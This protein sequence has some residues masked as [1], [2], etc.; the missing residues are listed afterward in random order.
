MRPIP[1][2]RSAIARQGD[3]VSGVALIVVSG[4]ASL[5]V[6]LALLLLQAVAAERWSAGAHRTAA[7]SRLC[8]ASGMNYAAA[9]LAE[10]PFPR[11]SEGDGARGDDWICRQ[12]PDNPSYDH[13]EHWTDGI[14]LAS[15][16]IDNDLDAA[17]D[18]PGEGAGMCNAGEVPLDLDG[19][20]RRSAWSGRLRGGQGA[21]DLRF[22]LAVRSL[23]GGIPLNAGN[24][25]GLMHVLDNLGA[26]V[27]IGARSQQVPSSGHT[28]LLS[29]LGQD[30]VGSRPAAGY[31]S[32]K[33]VEE[34]LLSRGFGYTVA[35]VAKIRPFI[36]LGP[37][38]A[39]PECSRR[40]S[41][42]TGS[43]VHGGYA[44]VNLYAARG[45]VLR[46]LWRY[47]AMG[48]GAY[49]W[50]FI[51]L[52]GEFTGWYRPCSWTGGALTFWD[53]GLLMLFPDEADRLAARAG[54]ARRGG[55]LTWNAFYE[56]LV[57]N[58]PAIFA[59][60]Y[61]DLGADPAAPIAQNTCV[62]AK[63]DLAFQAV[64][65]DPLP[66]WPDF[67]QAKDDP[68]PWTALYGWGIDRDGDGSDPQRAFCLNAASIGRVAYPPFDPAG[69]RFDVP[70]RP[71]RGYAEHPT[72]TPQGLTLAPPSRFS[73]ECASF[74][75]GRGG[76]AA[77]RG[78]LDAGETLELA[79]QEDFERLGGMFET[80][81]RRG[82]EI[83]DDPSPEARLD[84]RDD[85]DRTYP[86]I[87]TIPHQN[88]R[89]LTPAQPAF[90]RVHGAVGL[91]SRQAGLQG[92]HLYWPFSTDF[93]RDGINEFC[94]E[95]DVAGIGPYRMIPSAQPH[96]TVNAHL[97]YSGASYATRL[98]YPSGTYIPVNDLPAFQ[99]GAIPGFTWEAWVSPHKRCRIAY[100]YPP[101]YPQS[102]QLAAVPDWN[103]VS[104]S[105]AGRW[106]METGATAILS[107]SPWYMPDAAGSRN[108]SHN[109]HVALVADGTLFTLYV[110]GTRTVTCSLPYR[111][112]GAFWG[113]RLILLGCVEPRFYDRPLTQEEVRE[114]YRLGRYVRSG[115]YTSPLYV[116]D[117]PVRLSHAQWTGV[118]PF[119][120]VNASGNPVI[121]VE[122]EGYA[123]RP[124]DP[125][126]PRLATGFPATLAASG[127]LSNL[128]SLQLGTVRSFRYR[129]AFDCKTVPGTLHDT[130][131]LES[132]WFAFRR[133]G[134]AS[135]WTKWEAR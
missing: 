118:L 53:M 56:E 123:T 14:P 55:R 77:A 90:S 107:P 3:S 99:G 125:G 74:V 84:V 46:A 95:S 67:S 96:P 119:G 38:Q 34:S 127:G 47:L 24:R 62:Q 61:Q 87:M 1:P 98:D 131:F 50:P 132:I 135:T 19:D 7:L 79:S 100:Q 111:L 32:W 28:F 91:A 104:Y 20:G 36:D 18:E 112:A 29:W 121:A 40:L 124:G 10:D 126:H 30:L 66:A 25:T 58:A 9:R 89:G 80:L 76:G 63:A 15:D 37:Y 128:S 39:L 122:L 52:P 109:H 73:V 102:I 51:N 120:C 72:F 75:N 103:G 86:H 44:P 115:T 31:R 22:S 17:V 78:D 5:L 64:C 105:F 2:C 12:G 83:L 101:G 16:G 117:A 70:D 41:S 93:N 130:P 134:M 71:Y 81:A 48:G 35:D 6:M 69:S 106:P 114:R 26:I 110:D 108:E 42:W 45:E 129:V 13:G 4:L 8:A 60:D 88:F 97:P 116:P 59:E 85:G 54:D 113:R 94:S 23:D 21:R 33:E 82:I 68:Y 43:E 49:P 57:W 133:R 11:Y 27:G 92:A 65:M